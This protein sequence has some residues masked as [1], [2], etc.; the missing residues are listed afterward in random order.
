MRDKMASSCVWLRLFF[1]FMISEMTV[2]MPVMVTE[3]AQC[4]YQCS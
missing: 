4:V 2:L 1:S 3:S